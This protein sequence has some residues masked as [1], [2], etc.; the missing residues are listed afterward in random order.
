[1]GEMQWQMEVVIVMDRS[2]GD[3]SL[4]VREASQMHPIIKSPGMLANKCNSTGEGRS[5]YHPSPALWKVSAH[6]FVNPNILYRKKKTKCH[7]M[8]KQKG[9]GNVYRKLGTMHS[10]FLVV[11]CFDVSSSSLR[12]SFPVFHDQ[13]IGVIGVSGQVAAFSAERFQR[14][15][16]VVKITHKIAKPCFS[17]GGQRI[18]VENIHS[19]LYLSVCH[20]QPVEFGGKKTPFIHLLVQCRNC[21]CFRIHSL[22][23]SLFSTSSGFNNYR[24]LLNLGI[25]LLVR[26]VAH[27]YQPAI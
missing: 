15:K 6:G 17:H 20:L 19:N 25:V 27:A 2:A 23:D 26:N 5:R 1:M 4:A 7:Q 21:R 14:E 24:G 16:V 18:K 3:T 13:N 8:T 9:R 22:A 12:P 11:L 10:V